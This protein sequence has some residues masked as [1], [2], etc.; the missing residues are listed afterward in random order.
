MGLCPK[1]KPL[2][3]L[4]DLVWTHSTSFLGYHFYKFLC[5]VSTTSSC[6]VGYANHWQKPKKSVTLKPPQKLDEWLQ[7][8]KMLKTHFLKTK[9]HSLDSALSFNWILSK[10]VQVSQ[11]TNVKNGLN[12]L[13]SF[14]AI[15]NYRSFRPRISTKFGSQTNVSSYSFHPDFGSFKKW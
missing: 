10:C 2:S 4:N 8:Q 3:S 13:Y 11:V 14:Q 5:F 12:A 15:F 1:P 7:K 6:A 9:F